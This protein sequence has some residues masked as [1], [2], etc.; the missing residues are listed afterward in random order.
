MQTALNAYTPMPLPRFLLDS[1]S[2]AAHRDLREQIRTCLSRRCW[3]S[4]SSTTSSSGL[5][6]SVRHM[7]RYLCPTLPSTTQGG[8]WAKSRPKDVRMGAGVHF[9]D[10]LDLGVVHAYC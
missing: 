10:A 8:V 2:P 4:G 1:D 7:H 9:S 5:S 3:L 6:E